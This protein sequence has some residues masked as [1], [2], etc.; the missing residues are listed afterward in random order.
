MLYFNTG[1]RINH[2]VFVLCT[3][4]G[5][6]L[7]SH[8]RIISHERV[9]TDRNQL[10]P[11]N[12]DNGDGRIECTVSSGEASFSYSGHV[13]SNPAPHQATAIIPVSDFSNFMNFEGQCDDIY[14]YVFISHGE[15]MSSE[16][17][18]LKYYLRRN[19]SQH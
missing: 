11:P 1:I 2:A 18:T 5:E 8:G 12:N 3:L 7:Y 14:H 9:I 16:V 10:Q 15:V 4:G 13:V 19:R 17:C 6:V